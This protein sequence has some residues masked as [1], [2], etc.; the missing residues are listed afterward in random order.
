VAFSADG[1]PK[2]KEAPHI[3]EAVELQMKSSTQ[4]SSLS[5]VSRCTAE[6]VAIKAELFHMDNCFYRYPEKLIILRK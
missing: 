4:W 1:N 3:G 6:H 2:N 5:V